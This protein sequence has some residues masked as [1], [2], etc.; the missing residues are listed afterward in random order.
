MNNDELTS[1]IKFNYDPIH[2]NDVK[3]FSL[4]S[5]NN[6]NNIIQINL[7]FLELLIFM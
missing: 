6:N 2:S 3:E 4:P 7:F 1:K 5:N